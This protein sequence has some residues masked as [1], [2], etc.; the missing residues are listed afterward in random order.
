VRGA[1]ATSMRSLTSIMMKR[2]SR[3]RVVV[4]VPAEAPLDIES[5]SVVIHCA[6]RFQMLDGE[7]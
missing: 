6:Q 2:P 1:D 7:G 3:C 4:F 5:D